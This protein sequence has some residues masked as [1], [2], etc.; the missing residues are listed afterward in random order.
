[1][2][3]FSAD[4]RL[5]ASIAPIGSANQPSTPGTSPRY[6]RSRTIRQAIGSIQ[7]VFCVDPHRATAS[8]VHCAPVSVQ[9]YEPKT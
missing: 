3:H 2:N 9:L 4:P 8:S 1:M 5:C 6:T 7:D